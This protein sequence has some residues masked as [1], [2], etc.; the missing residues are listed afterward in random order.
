MEHCKGPFARFLHADTTEAVLTIIL[1]GEWICSFLHL[2]DA[3][4]IFS[5]H[6]S[7]QMVHV[8]YFS[9]IAVAMLVCD[10]GLIFVSY[11]PRQFLNKKHNVLYL[12]Y[13]I[14]TGLL[15][16][17][18]M[19]NSSPGGA[20]HATYHAT[21]IHKILITRRLWNFARPLVMGYLIEQLFGRIT[22][23]VHEHVH[24]LRHRAHEI[25]IRSTLR[26][27]AP[28]PP[29]RDRSVEKESSRGSGRS[30]ATKRSHRSTVSRSRSKS[31]SKGRTGSKTPSPPP[32]ASGKDS[33]PKRGREPGSGKLHI[34]KLRERQSREKQSSF[35][36]TREAS[37]TRRKAGRSKS[38][39]ASSK[40]GTRRRK[41]A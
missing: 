21:T 30:T 39:G 10:M 17:Y 14:L 3:E 19:P 15:E 1:A 38:K 9:Q 26:E 7:E 25:V 5:A 37:K 31:K 16:S 20:F 32:S 13:T 28:P 22:G 27:H 2:L 18:I 40:D 41:A 8:R 29:R 12:V 24:H 4:D 34:T 11:G 35:A 33:V 36:V 6:V 23:P